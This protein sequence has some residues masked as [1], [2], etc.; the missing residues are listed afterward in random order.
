MAEQRSVLY[1]LAGAK[2]EVETSLLHAGKAYG[3]FCKLLPRARG[4]DAVA[5]LAMLQVLELQTALFLELAAE[6]LERA[7][8]EETKGKEAA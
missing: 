8:G 1:S 7:L 6:G 5:A 4:E 3:R 2:K